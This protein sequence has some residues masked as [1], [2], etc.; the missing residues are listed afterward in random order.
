MAT[1]ACGRSLLLR[2]SPAA[3]VATASSSTGKSVPLICPSSSSEAIYRLGPFLV[4]IGVRGSS[5]RGPPRP[6]P[7]PVEAAT[8]RR[9]ELDLQHRA[10]C[11]Q[12]VMTYSTIPRITMYMTV[13]Q[14][15][16]VLQ[17]LV[18]P[19]TKGSWGTTL[20]QSPILEPALV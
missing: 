5:L 16:I 8:K 20:S 14:T 15:V 7:I 4:D 2:T 1:F 13:T 17:R 12:N 11:K 10:I 18:Q 6:K 9:L 19:L 3:V